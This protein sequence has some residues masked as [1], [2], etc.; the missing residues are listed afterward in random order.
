MEK[1]RF[2]PL[3]EE[4]KQNSALYN[5]WYNESEMK[6]GNLPAHSIYSWMVDVLEPIV[7]STVAL[8]STPEKTHQIVK[9]L[10]IESLK[11]IGSGL[12]IS[13]K[14]EYQSAWLLMAKNP[15]LLIKFPTK[16]ISLLNDVLKR[17]NKY[18]PE[19]ILDW[20]NLMEATSGNFKTIEDFK[21][22]GRI[23]AWKC[24]LA[25]LRG[26]LKLDFDLL[27]EE[28]QSKVLYNLELGNNSE[29]VYNKPWTNGITKFE[30]IYGGFEGFTGYFEYPPKL[31][32][33]NGTILVTDTK[34]S[35]ALFADQCGKTLLPAN[36]ITATNI[37]SNSKRIVSLEKWIGQENSKIEPNNISSIVTTKDTLVYTL[38]N[39]YFLYLYSLKNA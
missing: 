19:R 35:Y 18:A 13:H 1:I 30:G 34:K 10:Y 6:Y 14:N 26:L 2:L 31:A 25:H 5:Q 39:S 24:G 7:K 32:L 16:T 28:L 3:I 11:L 15:N 37:L 29:E 21:V 17:L 36:M 22:V 23:Y 27:S 8:N 12:A 38:K 20:C 9:R 4:F 33:V